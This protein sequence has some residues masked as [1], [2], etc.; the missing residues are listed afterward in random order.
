MQARMVKQYRGYESNQH[1]HVFLA[2]AS[3]VSALLSIGTARDGTMCHN[4]KGS[5]AG[6]GVASFPEGVGVN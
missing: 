5:G 1:I 4:Q 6:I 3:P 2:L